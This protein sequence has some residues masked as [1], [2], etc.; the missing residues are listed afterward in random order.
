[1]DEDYEEEQED[2]GGE[3][4]PVQDDHVL[5][6]L[7]QNQAWDN[8]HG[9][10]GYWGPDGW[11]CTT[12]PTKEEKVEVEKNEETVEVEKNEE[13]VEVEKKE[14]T[15]EVEKKE[16]T[17]EVE[18]KEETVEVEQKEKKKDSPT[19]RHST[20]RPASPSLGLTA[21]PPFEKKDIPVKWGPIKNASA[22]LSIFKQSQGYKEK[23]NNPDEEQPRVSWWDTDYVNTI[24]DMTVAE[25]IRVVQEFTTFSRFLNWRPQQ[26]SEETWTSLTDIANLVF[27]YGAVDSAEIV[28]HLKQSTT[29]DVPPDSLR[30]LKSLRDMSKEQCTKLVYWLN[31]QDHRATFENY[32]QKSMFYRTMLNDALWPEVLA[33]HSLVWDWWLE[34]PQLVFNYIR[35]ENWKPFVKWFQPDPVGMAQV[36]ACLS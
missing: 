31:G 1:M 2:E 12:D 3:E 21:V 14:E 4:E 17:V 9:Y 11:A 28:R 19:R 33:A 25:K 15:V 32:G 26:L 16:E 18:K 36:H 8:W 20:K 6:A 22:A 27:K 34:S 10:G 23:E 24:A 5:E 13:T 7:P 30:G 35:G 29:P